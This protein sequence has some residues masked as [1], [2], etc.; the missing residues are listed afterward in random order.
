MIILI[1]FTWGVN[2]SVVK[3]KRSPIPVLTL[4][5]VLVTRRRCFRLLFNFRMLY[6]GASEGDSTVLASTI[7][8]Q[9]GD[10]EGGTHLGGDHATSTRST[11]TLP[12]YPP[13]AHHPIIASGA[14]TPAPVLGSYMF[15]EY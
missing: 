10:L 14:I 8:G 9:M 6:P 15:E 12:T 4:R 1:L 5:M 2:G 11:S 7:D 13:P 3:V